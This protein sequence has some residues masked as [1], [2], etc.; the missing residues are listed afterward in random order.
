MASENSCQVLTFSE[1]GDH[2]S[3]QLDGEV[4]LAKG[5]AHLHD[6]SRLEGEGRLPLLG[7]PGPAVL[8]VAHDGVNV[9][10]HVE[11]RVEVQAQVVAV[12]AQVQ[13]E[14]RG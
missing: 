13:H 1:A 2:P 5:D 10:V 12:F 8:A 7:P 14:A 4:C 6:T 11:A 9:S 3:L